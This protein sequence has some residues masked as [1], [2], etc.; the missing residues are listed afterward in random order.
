MPHCETFWGWMFYKW[1][2]DRAK[3]TG[4]INQIELGQT[5]MITLIAISTDS[6]EVLVSL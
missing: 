2:V 4:T 6:N 1:L 3:L 5:Q